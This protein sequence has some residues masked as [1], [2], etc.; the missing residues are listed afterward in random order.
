MA[1]SAKLRVDTGSRLVIEPH[2]K[3][4]MSQI[5]FRGLD[6]R[7]IVLINTTV[8]AL[9][10]SLDSSIVTIALPDM[11]RSLHASVVESMWVVMGYT[12]VLTALILP[13]SRLSDMKGRVRLYIIGFAVFTVASALCGF[14]QSGT[15]LVIFRLVQ[16]AGATIL[17]TSSAALVTDAFP[18]SQRGLAL[19]I[20]QMAGMAGFI[21]GIVLGGAIAQFA[22]WRY[23]FFINVPIGI[24]A[25]GWA[26][27]K[28]H[29]VSRP[30]KEAR[31][32]IGG[33]V[34][35]PLAVAAILGA[36]TLLV[37]GRIDALTIGLF[38]FGVI[39]LI[40]FVF[41]ERKAAQPMMD[42][43]LFKIRLFWT[44]NTSQFLNSLSRGA[45]M[46][47]ISWYLQAV[48]GNSPLEA[49]LKVFPLAL[50][51]L[52]L[53]PISGRLYDRIGSR[54]LSTIGLSFTLF[55]QLWISTFSLNVSYIWLAIALV[56]LGIGNGLFNVPNVSAIMGCVPSN[57]RG[58]AT[59]TRT[60]M[61]Y[62]GQT[63]CIAMTMAI[64]STVLSYHVLTGLF[65]GTGGSNALDGQV[66]MSGFHKVFLIGS[67]ITAI[68]IFFSNLRGKAN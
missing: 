43:S 49:G 56:I 60:L 47:I 12:L 61:L 11:S 53:A 37:T 7:W 16:G 58:V 26:L 39:M 9:M 32:D 17:I 24:F 29:E 13:L 25:T 48:L 64:L 55:A 44:A 35:F 54:W 4:V 33:M 59:G 41:I 8:G 62:T 52:A 36:M 18:A 3:T 19:G 42:L 67:G 34:T 30:E 57:R 1:Y 51:M 63:M 45:L 28:L 6:Y 31:F 66:F 21:L 27:L 46:F 20:N 10:S 15:Q 65:M 5:S 40:V 22:G 68:A 2:T 23:I 38:T 14:S 50:T